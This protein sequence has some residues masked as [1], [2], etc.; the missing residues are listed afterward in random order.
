MSN[1]ATQLTSTSTSVS[2]VCL[3]MAELAGENL[4]ESLR[5]GP[6]I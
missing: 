3:E 1:S 5:E 4:G 2:L 6:A